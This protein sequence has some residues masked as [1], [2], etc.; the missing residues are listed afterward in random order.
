MDISVLGAGNVGLNLLRILKEKRDVFR[1]RYRVDINVV[2]VSD[3]RTTVFEPN[4][5]DLGGEVIEAKAS[6]NLSRAE[7]K[8]IS[9]DEIFDIDNEV[10][11]DL[12]PATQDGVRGGRD[13][14]MKAFRKGRHV[15][16][17]NKAPPLA[18]HWAQIMEEAA[19]RGG[20]MIRYEATV[21]G[22]VP[23]FSFRDYCITP[24]EVISF[25]GGIVSLTV[26]LVMRMMARG[27]TASRKL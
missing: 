18:L 3:S 7:A 4:G 6:G 10:I 13:I 20:K 15:V 27:G 9:F 17:A 11:V 1:S 5:L 19:S 24:S 12:M 21:A 26:N 8:T 2:S 16:T 23:L 25:R 22:G 14:Y